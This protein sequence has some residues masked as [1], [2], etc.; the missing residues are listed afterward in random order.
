MNKEKF[1]Q[2]IKVESTGIKA[3][4]ATANE[5]LANI[6]VLHNEIENATSTLIP[7]LREYLNSIRSVRMALDTE[8]RNILQ[9]SQSLSE[10]TKNNKEI[11]EFCVNIGLVAHVVTDHKDIIVKLAKLLVKE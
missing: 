7:I 3:A 10:I 6:N 11:K 4:E 1:E 9:T 8:V 5:L 2:A